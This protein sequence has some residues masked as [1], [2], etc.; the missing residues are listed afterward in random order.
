MSDKQ[1]RQDV[2][3]E[4]D[5]EPGVN[6]AHIGVAAEKGVVTLSGHVSSYVEKLAAERAARRVKG[7]QAIAEEIEVRYPGE[8]K[9][10]DDEIARRALEI[11]RWNAIVPQDSVQLKVRDGWVTL[12][13]QL[14]WQY[15]KD[16]AEDELRRLSG[17]SGILNTITVRPRVQPVEVKRKIEDAFRRHAEVE[18]QRVRVSVDGGKVL[19]QGNVRD[20]HERDAAEKAAWSAPGVY[21]VEDRLSIV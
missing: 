3:D 16:A 1:L 4:L 17:V 19:L 2:L 6:A 9:T 8:K 5:F 21:A 10:A 14:D 7:V 18:A 11:L 12:T 20:W 13:G 15:Q